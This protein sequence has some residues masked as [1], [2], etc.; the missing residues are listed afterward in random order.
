MPPLRIKDGG[1]DQRP[2]YD[3]NAA[4]KVKVQMQSG[5]SPSALVNE[6]PTI[7]SAALEGQLSTGFHPSAL[8]SLVVSASNLSK[9]KGSHQS[10]FH[11]SGGEMQ[12]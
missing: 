5:V 2:G 11:P 10:G 12:S 7:A 8:A 6:A 3:A 9:G 1:D 4:S